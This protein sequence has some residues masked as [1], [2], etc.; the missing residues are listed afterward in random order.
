ME[1]A[2]R[3]SLSDGDLEDSTARL[4]LL[5]L[6]AVRPPEDE[7]LR[8]AVRSFL[9]PDRSSEIL[10]QAVLVA[11]HLKDHGGVA[12]MSGLLLHARPGV[13]AVAAA[14]LTCGGHREHAGALVRGL[15]SDRLSFSTR[16]Q[17]QD[18]R[19]TRRRRKKTDEEPQGRGF[20]GS[21]GAEK[22][23]DRALLDVEVEAVHRPQTI[24]ISTQVVTYNCLHSTAL[25]N[26]D[27]QLPSQ[28]CP[29]KLR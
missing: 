24:E 15:R 6:R 19:R 7:G 27:D 2:I 21:V 14:F 17:T 26:C 5:R 16:V 25:S 29:V 23:E 3:D 9:T 10:C 4:M 1:K 8:E 20:P 28:H 12:E 18:S 11:H 13:R 22:R